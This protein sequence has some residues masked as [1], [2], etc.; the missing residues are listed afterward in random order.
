MFSLGYNRV[1]HVFAGLMKP[2]AALIVKL[3][4]KHISANI[5]YGALSHELDHLTYLTDPV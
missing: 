5:W 2:G 4:G 3:C 1:A